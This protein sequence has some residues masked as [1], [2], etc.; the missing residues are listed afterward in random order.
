[1]HP[2]A[3]RV[4]R[5]ERQKQLDLPVA[6]RLPQQ[7]DAEHRAVERVRLQGRLRWFAR[8]AHM[9]QL[10]PLQVLVRGQVHTEREIFRRPPGL[11]GPVG[12]VPD[13]RPL[14]AARA[15]QEQLFAQVRVGERRGDGG[16]QLGG[17]LPP[18]EE[19]AQAEVPPLD[20][21]RQHPPHLAP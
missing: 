13:G 15:H 8:R 5:R 16:R 19:A 4:L 10:D 20:A 18:L 9:P 14:F 1:M 3:E 2:K 21:V 12:R 17:H 11:P 6:L 7:R